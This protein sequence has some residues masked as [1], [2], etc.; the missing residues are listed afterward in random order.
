[1]SR[2]PLCPL[3]KE[4]MFSLT[5]N[6]RA[7]PDAATWRYSPSARSSSECPSLTYTSGSASSDG[8]LEDPLLADCFGSA[9]ADGAAMDIDDHGAPTWANSDV[10]MDFESWQQ[11]TWPE[12]IQEV[13]TAKKRA[14][15]PDCEEAARPKKI[16]R[17]V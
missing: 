15:S 2:V 5:T 13:A 10:A 4:I 3:V 11:G 1:M 7:A 12:D 9:S 17:L 16:P 8:S 6:G 14:S